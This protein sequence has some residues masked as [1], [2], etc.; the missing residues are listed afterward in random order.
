MKEFLDYT[1]FTLGSFQL[2]VIALFYLLLFLISI[3]VFLKIIKRFIYKIKSFDIAKKYAV[4][5]LLKYFVLATS[6][7]I[8]LQIIGFNLSLLIAGSA[9]LLVG[10]GMGMQNLFSDYLSGIVIL[11]DSSVK[12]GDIIEVNGM[13]CKVQEIH[14]RTTMVLTRDEKNIIL[15]NTDLTRNHLINWTLNKASSRF[16]VSIGVDYAS[17]VKLVMQLLIDACNV[18]SGIAKTPEP[19]VRFS[20][21]GDSSLKF[22]V[23]FWADEVFRVEKIKSELRIRI[24]ELF[25]EHNINIPYPQR[26]IHTKS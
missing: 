22:T 13:I 2:K 25:K 6:A 7:A 3:F 18:Q 15:P 24:F 8:S 21:F 19:F 16:E 17:D 23:G 20:D 9:A 10:L 11:V 4:Y 14:L 1:L 12:V 5:N 26:V